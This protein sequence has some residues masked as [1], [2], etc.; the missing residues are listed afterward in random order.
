MQRSVSCFDGGQCAG[1]VLEGDYAEFTDSRLI[2]PSVQLPPPAPDGE[3]HLRFTHWFSYASGDGSVVQISMLDETTGAWS[4]WTN[5]GN[6]IGGDSTVWSLVDID[7]TR[8]ANM[9]PRPGLGH[10]GASPHS[11]TLPLMR[12][13]IH[14]SLWQSLWPPPL[15]SSVQ[16]RDSFLLGAIPVP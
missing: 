7:L 4:A 12:N 1:T 13:I 11:S 14:Q 15:S 9:N 16:T 8:Y 6:P 5:V 10:L 2:S 3:I